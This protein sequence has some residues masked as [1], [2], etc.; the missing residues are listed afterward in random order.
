M[1]RNRAAV[2]TLIVV[3]AA[4]ALGVLPAAA[5]SEGRIEGIVFE[6]LNG[7]GVREAGEAGVPDVEV[8]F[9]SG[10]WTLLI[11]TGTDGTFGMDLNP[12]TW[13]VTVNAPTG[14]RALT[15]TK[16]VV[17]ANPGDQVLDVTFALVEGAADNVLPE[18]GGP[19]SETAIIGGLAGL[20]IVGLALVYAGQ[21]RSSRSTAS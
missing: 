15:S 13:T 21:R 20:L 14:M 8:V 5:Q 19:I 12:G 4:L 3:L 18:S 2:G 1:K 11:T 6:D 16:E 7:N 9:E 17:I 10:G